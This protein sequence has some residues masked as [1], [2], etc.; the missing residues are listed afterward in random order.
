MIQTGEV[1]A[2]ATAWQE[3]LVLPRHYLQPTPSALPKESEK[4]RA[5]SMHNF[6]LHSTA[7]AH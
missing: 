6:Y 3:D 2:A 7:R 4:P 1:K 5:R